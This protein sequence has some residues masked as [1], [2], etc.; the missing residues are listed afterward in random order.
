MLVAVDVSGLHVNFA[1][2]TPSNNFASP[3]PSVNFVSPGKYS[4]GG[5]F[6]GG[7]GYA[8]GRH[9]DSLLTPPAISVG[10]VGT[11]IGT[12]GHRHYTC[13]SPPRDNPTQTELPSSKRFSSGGKRMSNGGA[14]KLTKKAKL[15]GSGIVMMWMIIYLSLISLQKITPVKMGVCRRMGNY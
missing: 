7:A 6:S 10:S 8:T 11:G 9:G 3:T 13:S 15:S 5:R 2:L 14:K 4:A 1:S 12:S